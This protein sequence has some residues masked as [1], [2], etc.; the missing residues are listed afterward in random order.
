MLE[1]DTEE[2]LRLVEVVEAGGCSNLT[3]TRS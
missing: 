1:G 3:E 2:A